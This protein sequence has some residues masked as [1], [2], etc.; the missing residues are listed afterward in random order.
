MADEWGAYASHTLQLWTGLKNVKSTQ[1][2]KDTVTCP[3]QRQSRRNSYMYYGF[4][5]WGTVQFPWL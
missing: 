5:A 4:L 3:K 2:R 1:L